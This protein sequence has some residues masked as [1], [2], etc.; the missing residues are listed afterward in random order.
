[1][2]ALSLL[3]VVLLAAY[4][5]A[6]PTQLTYQIGQEFVFGM[7]SSVDARHADSLTLQPG[8]GSIALMNST[9]VYQCTDKDATSYLFVMNMF[10]TTVNV[11]QN[12]LSASEVI[13]KEKATLIGLGSNNALGDN[14]YFQQLKTGEIVKIWYN[15]GDSP[16]FVNVKA[17]AINQFQTRVVPANQQTFQYQETDLIGVHNSDFVGSK[18]A[19][20]SLSVAKSFDQKDFTKFATD[21]SLSASDLILNANQGVSVHPAGYIQSTSFS[22]KVLLVNTPPAQHGQGKRDN[23]GFNMFMLSNG[24]MNVNLQQVNMVKG[25][26]RTASSRFSPKET[27]NFA[28]LRSNRTFLTDSFH[29]YSAKAALFKAQNPQPMDVAEELSKIFSSEGGAHAFAQI[30]RVIRYLKVHKEYAPPP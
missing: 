26:M 5:A 29:G 14:M 10:D 7:G 23:N 11:G 25:P 20:N 24:Q 17:G 15:T 3:V 12:S 8:G 16:Y 2:K 22:Q 1:M 21:P 6:Q 13:F 27:Y 9:V 30:T 4:V 19:D 28:G 18:N